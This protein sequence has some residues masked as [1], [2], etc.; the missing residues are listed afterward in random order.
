MQDT[1]ILAHTIKQELKALRELLASKDTTRPLVLTDQEFENLRGEAG[2]DGRDGT[3][4]KTPKKG[5]DYLTEKEIA[6]LVKTIAKMVPRP[7]VGKDFYTLEERQKFQE[8]IERQVRESMPK[9]GVDYLT[10]KEEKAL[11]RKVTKAVLSEVEDKLAV[12][13]NKL[14]KSF[15][16]RFKAFK[17]QLGDSIREWVLGNGEPIA[18][19][20]ERLKGQDRLDAKAIKN[21][22]LGGG[23]G[24]GS[25]VVVGGFTLTAETPTGT[26]ND[27]NTSFTVSHEP[28]YIVVNG[29]QYT[30]G[31]GIYTSYAA[32]TIT[33][34]SAVGVG[35]FIKSF[36]NA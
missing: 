8:L 1:K 13:E 19:A 7:Q 17:K 32:G 35:G 23:G 28:L 24:G 33:L 10:D 4:G 26:V 9:K 18:R 31:D 3:N 2:R 16:E 11:L 5:V 21:I 12:S 22:P 6:S 29:A 36:Y 34:S 14:E 30:V 25:S 20:L 27:S 15:T